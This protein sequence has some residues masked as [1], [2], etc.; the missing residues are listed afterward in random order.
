VLLDERTK[1]ARKAL[2]KDWKQLKLVVFQN[3]V[4]IYIFPSYLF[5]LI[6]KLSLPPLKHILMLLT[7]GHD[8]HR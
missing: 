4:R 7:E 2:W 6:D 1:Y 3:K 8:L 5:I